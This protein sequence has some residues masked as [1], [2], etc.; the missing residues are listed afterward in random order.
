[1]VLKSLYV[2][3]DIWELA[4]RQAGMVPLAAIIRKLIR[5]WVTGKINLDDYADD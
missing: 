3:P 2:E 4:K 1:M 5:L